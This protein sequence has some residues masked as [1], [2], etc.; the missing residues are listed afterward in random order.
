MVQAQHLKVEKT[1]VLCGCWYVVLQQI[2]DSCSVEIY[3][4]WAGK[5]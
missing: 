5:V 2:I 4:I 1:E 3:N